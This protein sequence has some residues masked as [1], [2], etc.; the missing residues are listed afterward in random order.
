MNS[1]EQKTLTKEEKYLIKE[2]QKKQK[3]IAK[4]HKKIEQQ[5]IKQEEKNKKEQE[6]K[7]KEQEQKSAS[8]NKKQR[9][10]LFICQK[11]VNGITNDYFLWV[12][13]NQKVKKTAT[14][15]K[16]WNYKELDD[17]FLSKIAGED[18]IDKYDYQRAFENKT[19]AIIEYNK[20]KPYLNIEKN[21]IAGEEFI[22]IN[23]FESTSILIHKNKDPRVKG[24]ISPLIEFYDSFTDGRGLEFDTDIMLPIFK[25]KN[26]LKSNKLGLVLYGRK[27]TGKSLLFM[28]IEGIL[29]LGN[30]AQTSFTTDS[31]K[32][33]TYMQKKL[34]L[35][36]N[37][38]TILT[39]DVIKRLKE[40]GTSDTF[41][42]EGK[43]KD[44][45]PNYPFHAMFGIS[46][47]EL[48][49]ELA[50]ANEG[51]RF[52]FL[53]GTKQY[54]ESHYKIFKEMLPAIRYHYDNHPN[55]DKEEM[56]N[57]EKINKYSKVKSIIGLS[58]PTL[59][60]EVFNNYVIDKILN[61]DDIEEYIGS[62]GQIYIPINKQVLSQLTMDLKEES[63]VE[64]FPNNTTHPFCNIEL[65]SKEMIKWDNLKF[66]NTGAKNH[67]TKKSFKRA[68]YCSPEILFGIAQE[69]H[70]AIMNDLG[71]LKVEEDVITNITQPKEELP[72]K[73]VNKV[74][75]ELPVED[76][77]IKQP[78]EELTIADIANACKV[79]E[80]KNKEDLKAELDLDDDKFNET[81]NCLFTMQKILNAG[82]LK[83]YHETTPVAVIQLIKRISRC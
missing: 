71:I 32:F 26:I 15:T 83:A 14:A 69:K 43:G 10:F 23:L 8:Y 74:K 2:E 82:N 68:V 37:D 21:N 28:I 64:F 50:D 36:S 55:K 20:D 19:N 30:T 42:I 9:L 51:K 58:L 35:Y 62:R 16:K 4:L 73:E 70:T 49:T 34:F 77:A 41:T 3:E 33:N 25:D 17:E 63:G 75:E 76:I 40:L 66:M 18:F 72:V 65:L 59:A 61:Q 24:D 60:R 27:S 13:K 56:T 67:R 1:Q 53:E 7:Q 5:R 52:V 11:E 31:M 6:Q 39:P 79:L 29:G 54:E 12:Y 22:S 81:K 57:M 46:C 47:E 38:S 44:K 80:N 48:P 78:K 45:I